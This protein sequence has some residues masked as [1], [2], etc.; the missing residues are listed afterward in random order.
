MPSH[1][2]GN[3]QEECVLSS[4]AKMD[5]EVLTVGDHQLTVLLMVDLRFFLDLHRV[6]L[7]DCHNVE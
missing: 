2:L 4:K 5:S 1:W 6:H 7:H 3:A